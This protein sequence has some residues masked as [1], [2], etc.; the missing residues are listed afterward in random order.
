MKPAAL[1]LE[2]A[3][4]RLFA[5][6]RPMPTERRDIAAALGCYLAADLVAART[7]PA[8]DMSAM[9]GYAVC[10]ADLTGPWRLVGESAAGHPYDGAVRPGETVRVSTGALMPRGGTTVI[11]QEDIARDGQHVTLCGTGPITPERHVRVRG[12]DFA[13]EDVLLPAGTRIGP[14]QSALAIAAGVTQVNVHR[15]PHVAVI[16]TGD[17]L[18]REGEPCAL[19]QIPASNGP[20][21]AAMLAALPARVRRIGPVPDELD[22][23]AQALG[24][25]GDADVI[26]TTGGAS[27]GDH[28]L[29]RPA[30]EAWGAQLDFWRV[31][32]KPGK[33]L[34]VATREVVGKRQVILG[35]P[36]NPAAAYVTGLLFMLPLLRHLLGAREPLPQRINATL[37]APLRAGGSRREFLRSRWSGDTIAPQ[38]LQDSGVLRSLAASNALIDRPANAPPAAI[39]DIVSGYLLDNGGMA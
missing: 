10:T 33:P 14:V 2:E 6:A 16:D 8:A 18:R 20:M 4:A 26:V 17:E 9:D 1:S 24:E 37:S 35:L 27:V 5:Q 12:L 15:S 29:I 31:A 34:L 22:H 13:A 32:I 38:P 30:L 21:L 11:L 7:Q 39:G 19:H 25:S 23:I 36:G 28:D 3:Q